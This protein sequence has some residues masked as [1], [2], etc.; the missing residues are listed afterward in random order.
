[1]QNI[2]RKYKNNEIFIDDYV[3]NV[4]HFGNFGKKKYT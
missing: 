3:E 2:I 4:A 1:M